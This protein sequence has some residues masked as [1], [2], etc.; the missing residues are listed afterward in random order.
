MHPSRWPHVDA[1]VAAVTALDAGVVASTVAVSGAAAVR[2]YAK[3]H[4]KE[5]PSWYELL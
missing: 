5:N 1:V 3:N 4:G 2:A